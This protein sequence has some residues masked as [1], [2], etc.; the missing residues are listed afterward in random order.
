MGGKSIEIQINR[1]KIV[2]IFILREKTPL[3]F[4]QNYGKLQRTHEKM[5][6]TK[7]YLHAP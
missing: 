7:K 2:E 5:H 1:E 4:V 6:H 3:C